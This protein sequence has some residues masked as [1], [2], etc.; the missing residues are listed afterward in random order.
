MYRAY[1]HYAHVTAHVMCDIG[2]FSPAAHACISLQSAPYFYG[3]LFVASTE[4]RAGQ[5]HHEEAA[6]SAVYT[7]KHSKCLHRRRSRHGCVTCSNHRRRVPCRSI[8]LRYVSRARRRVYLYG[9]GTIL[10][11]VSGCGSPGRANIVWLL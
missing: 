8:P 10:P 6:V 1:K 4:R 11:R 3:F 2:L 9:S 5:R 7:R